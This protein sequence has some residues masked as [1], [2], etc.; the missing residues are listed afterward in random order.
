MLFQYL[1]GLHL[2]L[3]TFESVRNHLREL[4]ILTRVAQRHAH[5]FGTSLDFG[6][7][8]FQIHTHSFINKFCILVL[9]SSYTTCT[10]S[11]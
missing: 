10:T 1:K 3:D 8:F 11:D 2:A 4:V 6:D 7:V 5:D 9:S